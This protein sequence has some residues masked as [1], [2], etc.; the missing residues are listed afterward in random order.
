MR[1][2]DGARDQ[3]GTRGEPRQIEPTGRACAPANQPRGEPF[4][5]VSAR[6]GALPGACGEPKSAVPFSGGTPGRRPESAFLAPRVALFSSGGPRARENLG[7]G[8]PT[9]NWRGPLRPHQGVIGAGMRHIVFKAARLQCGLKRATLHMAPALPHQAYQCAPQSTRIDAT[10]PQLT[11]A[12]AW[13][14]AARRRRW[15]PVSFRQFEQNPA[16]REP[17]VRMDRAPEAASG[18]LT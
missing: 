9:G 7:I 15:A 14:P 12:R 2:G 3:R 16:H 18:C 8:A 6:S 10:I 11:R 4:Q 5:A 17:R 1:D 13:R